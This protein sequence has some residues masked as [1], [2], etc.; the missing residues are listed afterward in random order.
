MAAQ[1]YL[2]FERPLME[3]EKKIQDLTVRLEEKES[4]PMEPPA[5][6]ARSRRGD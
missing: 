4:Q 6:P 2:E 5:K 3:L 1:F